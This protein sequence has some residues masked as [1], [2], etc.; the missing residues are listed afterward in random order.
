MSAK[1]TVMLAGTIGTIVGSY[2]PVLWGGTELSFI[3][4]ILGGVGGVAAVILAYKIVR[5]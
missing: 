2:I 3:S 5:E 1:N 4:L